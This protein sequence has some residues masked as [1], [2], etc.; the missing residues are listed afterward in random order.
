MMESWI[1]TDGDDS[2]ASDTLACS[3]SY[4]SLAHLL[5]HNL[6]VFLADVKLTPPTA[7]VKAIFWQ[8]ACSGS[9]SWA[10]CSFAS[11]V[12]EVTHSSVPKANS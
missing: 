3:S 11:G 8:A 10:R 5:H 7:C 2:G 6:M 9:S 1:V 4:M 12:V